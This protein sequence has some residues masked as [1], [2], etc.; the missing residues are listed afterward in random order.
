MRR[1]SVVIL[2]LILVIACRDVKTPVSVNSFQ[3][4]LDSFLQSPE[5]SVVENSYCIVLFNDLPDSTVSFI[6]SESPHEL[7][8]EHRR[9]KTR[10]YTNDKGDTLIVCSPASFRF[11][12][13]FQNWKEIPKQFFPGSSPRFFKRVYYVIHDG[14]LQGIPEKTCSYNGPRFRFFKSRESDAYF[15]FNRQVPGY[16]EYFDESC[17]WI[18]TYI[19]VDSTITFIPHHAVQKMGSGDCLVPVDKQPFLI[20]T[21]VVLAQD[22]RLLMQK[23]NIF[24][25]DETELLCF[26]EVLSF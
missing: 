26:D 10:M 24:I 14:E 16:A 22:T 11:E 12:P 15:L 7:V 9:T 1:K 5:R 3:E 23:D 13:L 25:P 20:D 19:K 18:G 2:L 4:E 8:D 6:L 21:I 17:I